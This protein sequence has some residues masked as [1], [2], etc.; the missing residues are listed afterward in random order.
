VNFYYEK[1][2]DLVS[3]NDNGNCFL[4]DDIVY[5]LENVFSYKITKVDKSLAYQ[6]ELS[7]YQIQSQLASRAFQKGIAHSIANEIA[8]S[9]V[10]N[11][12]IE[13]PDDLVVTT[14]VLTS[15]E[16][17]VW[18]S[19]QEIIPSLEFLWAA[20]SK[21]AKHEVYYFN[22]DHDNLKNKLPQ[23]LKAQNIFVTCF[24]L[25]ISKTIQL[26]RLHLNIDARLVIQIHNM[27]T[28]ACWPFHEWKM[29]ETFRESD[30]FI[31]TCSYDKET[32]KLTYPK[33]RVELI[34][35]CALELEKVSEQK[36][37]NCP[38]IFAYVGRISVQKN[39]HTILAALSLL[40]NKNFEFYLYGAEDNLGSPNM[41]DYPK[42]YLLFLKK[43]TGDLGLEGKVFFKGHYPREKLYEEL[44]NSRVVLL[45]ASLHSDENF[46]MALFRGLLLGQRV[47]CSDW[48]GHADFQAHFPKQTKLVPVRQTKKG[49]QVSPFEFAKMIGEG[50]HD[51]AVL[52]RIP[53]HY[54]PLT[55]SLKIQSLACEKIFS[56]NLL[57]R[58]SFA[59]KIHEKRAMFLASPQSK[60]CKVFE[61]YFDE[62]SKP[63]FESY[64]MKNSRS[65]GVTYKLPPWVVINKEEITVD[66]YHRGVETY[67]CGK[68]QKIQ[69]WF[70]REVEISSDEF[71]KMWDNG[72]ILV[73][74]N[75]LCRDGSDD[76]C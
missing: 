68:G 36:L 72:D 7:V 32:L 47:V 4:V 54:D 1:I 2:G 22:V 25:Q 66:D 37:F 74:S 43:L 48:G 41:E 27:A 17:F 71:Q 44:H 16:N 5:A 30:V 29:G 51:L 67:S 12:N 23:F 65:Q 3:F 50:L 63:L 18:Q 33:G 19:M 11:N 75:E 15:E 45:T 69:T 20:S 42:D 8:K 38:T 34:P 58:S 35:F 60:G 55:L 49:P 46:G 26:L 61:D 52:P 53:Q 21:K 14:I 56:F 31:S 64:G 28:I 9:D 73:D 70:G 57:K 13:G 24:N 76:D 39:I 10:E 6:Y 40:G 59:E 62:L